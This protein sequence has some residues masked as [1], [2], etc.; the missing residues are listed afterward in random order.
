MKMAS[1]GVSECAAPLVI[2]IVEWEK[3]H[4]PVAGRKKIGLE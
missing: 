1:R 3:A 2:G 4:E